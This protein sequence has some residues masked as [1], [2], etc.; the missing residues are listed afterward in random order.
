MKTFRVHFTDGHVDVVASTSAAAR[1]QAEK[2][3][4]DQF[5]KKIKVLRS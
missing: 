4:P 3:H 1:E 5:I 2:N